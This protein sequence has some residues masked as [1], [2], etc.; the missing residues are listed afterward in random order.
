[1]SQARESA[2]TGLRAIFLSSNFKDI[3]KNDRLA[4]NLSTGRPID[5]LEMFGTSKVTKSHAQTGATELPATEQLTERQ[6][7]VALL[8]QQVA[9]GTYKPNLNVVAAKMLADLGSHN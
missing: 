7:K 2:K 9:D 1:M 3:Q 8:K 4:V 6:I 5:H